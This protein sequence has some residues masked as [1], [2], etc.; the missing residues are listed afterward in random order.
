M[1]AL[2]IEHRKDSQ[3]PYKKYMLDNILSC[4]LLDKT[5]MP[6]LHGTCVLYHDRT[7][8]QTEILISVL[9]WHDLQQVIEHLCFPSEKYR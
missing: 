6:Y 8:Q 5:A 9:L 7:S 1:E 2:R 4:V 3:A